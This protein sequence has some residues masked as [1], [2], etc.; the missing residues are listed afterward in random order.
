M[1]QMPK[2]MITAQ[3]LRDIVEGLISETIDVHRNSRLISMDTSYH[4]PT[5]PPTDEEIDDFIASNPFLDNETQEQLMDPGLLGF[6]AKTAQ[7]SAKWMRDFRK[8]IKDWYQN[9]TWLAA[10]LPWIVAVSP[11]L[12]SESEIWHPSQEPQ[13]SWISRSPTAILVAADLLRSGRLLSELPW[14]TFEELIGQLLESEGWSVNVTRPSKDGGIDVVALKND[15]TLGLIRS[16]WQAKRYGPRRHVRLSDV[17]ELGGIIDI[18][19]ATKG[20]VVT[21]GRLTKGALDWI[22]RDKY[23]LD[24]KDAQKMEAWVRSTILG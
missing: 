22:R 12:A 17:R 5:G 3:D 21:T 20:V 13:P 19:R 7:A 24:Y 16:L 14:R 8:H 10:D 23:R 6:A 2:L 1:C 15:A 11:A 9:N 18:D 4:P